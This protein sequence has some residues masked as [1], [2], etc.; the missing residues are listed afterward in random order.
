MRRG[1]LQVKILTPE[2]EFGIRLELGLASVL[3][4]KPPFFDFCRVPV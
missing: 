4:I 2:L 1:T 3:L